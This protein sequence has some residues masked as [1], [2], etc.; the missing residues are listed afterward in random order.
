[1]KKP[2]LTFLIA[3]LVGLTSY[4]QVD[5]KLTVDMTYQRVDQVSSTEFFDPA[6][7]FIDVAGSF[8]DWDGTDYHL[9]QV[10]DTDS[11]YE[12][13]L[14]GLT[15]GDVL[16]FKFR[17]NGTW[18]DSTSEFWGDQPNRKYNVRSE[19]TEIKLI[20][21]NYYPGWVPVTVNVNMNKAIDDAVFDPANDWVDL[22]GSFNN[23]GNNGSYDVLWDAVD[24]I[25]SAKIIA[26]VGDMEWKTRI[27][28]DWNTSEFPGGGPNRV[29][30]I[31]DTAGGVTNEISVWYSDEILSVNDKFGADIS[32]YPNPVRGVL[33]IANLDESVNG[34]EVYN[35]IGTKVK[36]ISTA[37]RISVDLDMTGLSSGVYFINVL[38][39]NRNVKTMKVV[40]Q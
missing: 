29:N 37:D 7:D 34:I 17:I 28:S 23:W 19:N 31:A 40:K 26:P 11:L 24:G 32:V 5:V 35:V 30:A 15:E 2:L 39:A 33:T 1:M 13:T 8:N 14:T 3:M 10:V 18:T 36:S 25:Y 6:N 20:F 22:A 4:A 38:D 9:T 16:E 12:I 27:N 21:D